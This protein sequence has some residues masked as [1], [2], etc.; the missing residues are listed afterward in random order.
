MS[1]GP[2]LLTGAGW[3]KFE[4]RA[5][6][7]RGYISVFYYVPERINQ[8]SQ[9][10]I[11]LHGLDRAASEFRD[12]FADAAE[13][14]GKIVL[15]PEYDL[16]SFPDVYSYNYGNVVT[17]PPHSRVNDTKLWSFALL[18]RLFVSTRSISGIQSEKFDL[19][20]NSAGSQYVLRYVALMKA[21]LLRKAISSNSGIYMMPDLEINYP[22]GM[23][24]KAYA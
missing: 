18:D 3:F 19:Y 20:G 9:T 1:D 24:G 14:L 21:S 10:L 23:G 12:Q 4:D 2:K 17:P 6:G 8:A 7:H 5:A 22:N 16:Q 13:R 15:V 11:A